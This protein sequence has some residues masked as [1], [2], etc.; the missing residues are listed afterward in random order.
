RQSTTTTATK[1]NRSLDQPTGQGP[2]DDSLISRPGCLTIVDTFRRASLSLGADAYATHLD[3]FG[4]SVV[5]CRADEGGNNYYDA[6][7]RS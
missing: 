4:L 6:V 2:K 7:K 3:R 1:T 5:S